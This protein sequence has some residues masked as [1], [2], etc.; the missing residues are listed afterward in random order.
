MSNFKIIGR[1]KQ[2][3]CYKSTPF[4]FTRTPKRN[5]TTP[6]INAKSLYKCYQQITLKPGRQNFL[7]ET[8]LREPAM[9]AISD[10]PEIKPV[11][12]GD[13]AIIEASQESNIKS[14]SIKSE[15]S[16]S[17]TENNDSSL[18][19]KDILNKF[20]HPVYDSETKEKPKR[21]KDTSIVESE[22]EIKFKNE[23]KAKRPKKQSGGNS[24]FKFY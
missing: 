16:E 22:S 14:D 21:K 6:G 19:I 4:I 9:A 8:S 10:G 2:Y 1:S 24:V 20:K 7:V 15:P 23:P 13:G 17:F 11:Q 18:T 3:L 5:M 12:K